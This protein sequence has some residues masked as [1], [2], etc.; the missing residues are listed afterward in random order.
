M[1]DCGV[2][3]TDSL[4]PAQS[5]NNFEVR[6]QLVQ[7]QMLYEVGLALS[8]SLDLAQVAEQVLH[9]ALA[10]VDA[11]SGLLL[12]RDGDDRPYIA[13]Q[14]GLGDAADTLMT[15]DDVAAAWAQGGCSNSI[16][17]TG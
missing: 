15:L 4:V 12:R 2:P 3:D 14:I 16:A 5:A 8:E 6:R 9:R 13:S 1:K 10:M 7:M 17:A 11:R